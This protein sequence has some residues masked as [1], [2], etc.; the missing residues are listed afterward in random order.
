[1]TLHRAWPAL[2]W[3]AFLAAEG[4]NKDFSAVVSEA[5]KNLRAKTQPFQLQDVSADENLVIRCERSYLF[6]PVTAFEKVFQISAK[7]WPPSIP[8][9]SFTDEFGQVLFG[10]F[11]ADEQQPFLRVVVASEKATCVSR[12]LL[13]G[14]RQLRAGQGS[15][16]ADLW[17]KTAQ[18]NGPKVLAGKNPPMSLEKAKAKLAEVLASRKEAAESQAQ[19]PPS[20]TP[21][22]EGDVAKETEEQQMDNEESESEVEVCPWEDPTIP[23][24]QG[25][26]KAME[27]PKSDPKAK[28][29]QTHQGSSALPQAKRPK[30]AIGT[31]AGSIDDGSSKAGSS[32]AGSSTISKWSSGKDGKDRTLTA[33][34]LERCLL[35][36][37]SER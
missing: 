13:Q 4:T 33:K 31:Q 23:M 28:R 36:I 35:G 17:S 29:K 9:D 27:K 16:V 2:T 8:L 24:A 26:Q 18:T 21:S 30:L 1:M 3:E 32:V 11:V 14:D 15:E 19:V 22:G 12:R 5:R 37:S 20:T 6:V 34:Y 7:E 10:L 25:K